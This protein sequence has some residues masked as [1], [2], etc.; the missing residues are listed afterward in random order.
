[1]TQAKQRNP[2]IKLYGLPWAFPAWV[3]NGTG[4][5]YAFPELTAGYIVKWVAGAKSVYDLDIDYVVRRGFC[6][7]IF[8]PLTGGRRA[9]GTSVRTTSRTLRRCGRRWMRRG[10]APRRLWRRILG[11]RLRSPTQ[12][13][14]LHTIF[15]PTRSWP[16]RCTPLVRTCPF[17]FP[18]TF[19][20]IPMQ[21][22]TILGPSPPRPLSTRA[23]RCGRART[24]RRTTT[25]AARAAGRAC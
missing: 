17:F 9:S 8:R 23:S 4:N 10:S 6:M 11:G 24:C 13:G 5:P 2:N 20:P 7:Q 12:G 3:G 14:T 25:C 15:W 19:N 22:R 21:A 18:S 1:M 16:M